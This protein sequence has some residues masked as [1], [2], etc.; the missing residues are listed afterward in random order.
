MSLLDSLQSLGDRL[1]I[2]ER[3][4]APTAKRPEKIQTRKITLAKLI[5]EIRADEVRA[6]ADLPA[7]LSLPFEKIFEAAGIASTS[8]GWNIAKLRQLLLTDDFKNLERAAVQKRIL[9]TLRTENVRVEDLVKDAVARDQA[10]DAFEKFAG[11]KMEERMV[12]CQHRV[13]EL[14]SK[15][16]EM[17][18]EC[19]HLREKLHADQ[20]T[21]RDW[22]KKKRAAECDLTWTVSFLIDHPVITTDIDD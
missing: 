7:E 9:N 10:L 6:L 13:A 17:Q 21:W 5:T 22:R 11:K 20:E 18:E 2:L 12:A 19:A 4:S 1:G 15:I 14:D 8:Q 3:V 16:K